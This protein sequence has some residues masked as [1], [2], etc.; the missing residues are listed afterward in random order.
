MAPADG[1][2]ETRLTVDGSDDEYPAWSP[3]GQFIVFNSNRYGYT[4][5][6][7]MRADGSSVIPL[8]WD[9]PVGYAEFAPA[10]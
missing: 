3:D 6:F 10:G 4:G 1:A 5:L 9:F 8:V 7:V 2:G